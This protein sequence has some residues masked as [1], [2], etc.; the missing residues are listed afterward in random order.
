[1]YFTYKIKEN[2]LT[3]GSDQILFPLLSLSLYIFI[4]ILS[5]NISTD[6]TFNHSAHPFGPQK[7][8]QGRHENVQNQYLLCLSVQFSRSVVSDSLRPHELQHAR[9]PCYKEKKINTL[10]GTGIFPLTLCF[11]NKGEILDTKDT[12]SDT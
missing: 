9:P 7:N 1:M 6:D 10:G 2:N 4:I 11:Y 5:N 8:T 12:L 3:L